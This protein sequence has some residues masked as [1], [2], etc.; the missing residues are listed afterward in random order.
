MKNNKLLTILLIALLCYAVWH[1][2][3]SFKVSK[4]GYYSGTVVDKTV[5]VGRSS[6]YYLYVDWDGFGTSSVIAHPVTYKRTEVGSRIS[7]EYMYTPFIGATG[8]AYVPYDNE[9][10]EVFAATGVL[11]K[12]AVAL[13]AVILWRRKKNVRNT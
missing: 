6:T 8:S 9:Y 2:V 12:I 5:S 11:S 4:E 1:E 10:N 13:I 3:V 7:A